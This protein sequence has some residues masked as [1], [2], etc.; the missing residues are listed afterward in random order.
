MA[1]D[2]LSYWLV[3]RGR[4]I[5]LESARRLAAQSRLGWFI[6]PRA[7]SKFSVGKITGGEKQ[8]RHFVT[9]DEGKVLVFDSLEEARTFLR[10]E[11]NVAFVEVFDI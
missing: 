1:Q 10:E 9:D 3:K 8:E 4:N 7:G 2:E 6:A 5:R 11:L